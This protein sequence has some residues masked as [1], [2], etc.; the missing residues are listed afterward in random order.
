MKS[1]VKQNGKKHILIVEDN[2]VNRVFVE[3]ILLRNGFMSTSAVNGK[4]A[5]EKYRENYYDL[6][7]MDIMMPCMDGY[8]ATRQIRKLEKA[9]T[10]IIALTADTHKGSREKC[11]SS[12][13][14]DFLQ[15]PVKITELL[16][17]IRKWI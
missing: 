14:N 2:E 6:V 4:E 11:F 5:L 10:P 17:A 16:R 13:V 7:I 1:K 9:N 12:G 8:E 3:N 15:K